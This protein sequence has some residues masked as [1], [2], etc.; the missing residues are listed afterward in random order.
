MDYLGTVEWAWNPM[1]SRIESY[2]LHAARRHWVLWKRDPFPND[3]AYRWLVAAYAPRAGV[4]ASTAA[5]HLLV[6]AWEAEAAERYLDH[7][8]WIAEVGQ[9]DVPDWMAI[10]RAVWPSDASSPRAA[11]SIAIEGADA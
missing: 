4:A 7:F 5:R 1:S 2:Y 10:G 6:A 9:L 3:E 11:N 8:H